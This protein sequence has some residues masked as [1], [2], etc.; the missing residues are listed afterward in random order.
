MLIDKSLILPDLSNFSFEGRKKYTRLQ[1]GKRSRYID[2]HTSA[3]WFINTQNHVR[4]LYNDERINILS[5]IL[6]FDETTL[7]GGTGGSSR[8]S[9]PLYVSIGNLEL[10]EGK[11]PATC[12]QCLGFFP[13]ILVSIYNFLI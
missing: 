6:S 2:S 12:V 9:T 5:V 11:L 1:N 7:T 13:E 4:S 8:T 10:Q 3:D